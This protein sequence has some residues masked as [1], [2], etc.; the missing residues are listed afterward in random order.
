MTIDVASAWETDDAKPP[1]RARASR[2]RRRTLAFL[3]R[4]R[5]RY[6]FTSIARRIVV[7]NVFGLLVLVAGILYLNQFRAGLIDNRRD[8]LLEHGKIIA[9][10]LADKA[11]AEAGRIAP[12]ADFMLQLP[13][14]SGLDDAINASALSFALDPEIVTPV[15]RQIA[16]LTG[17]RARIY[18]HEGVLLVDSKRLYSSGQVLRFDLPPVVEQEDG[19]LRRFWVWLGK[20]SADK[21]LPVHRDI[22]SANGKAYKEIKVALT[23]EPMNLVS[24]TEKGETIVSVG[25]P[26]QRMRTVMGALLLTSS[27]G[28]IDDIIAKERAAILSMAALV[29]LVTTVLS[30]LLAG[31]IAE[32]MRR[33]AAA[34]ERVPTSMRSPEPIPDFSHRSDEIGHLSR[35]LRNMTS[36]L[37]KRME[38]TECFAADVAHELKNP[39]TSLRSAADTL[40]LA[41]TDDDRAR[42]VGIIQHDVRRLDRLITDISDASRLD[43]ELSR[44]TAEPVDVAALLRAMCGAMNDLHREGAPPIDVRIED[45]GRRGERTAPSFM[46]RGH[47][48][49]LSQVI[50]NIIDNAVSFSPEGGKIYV[51]AR[52]VRRTREIEIAIEDEGPGIAPE[53]LQKVFARFY[54]D[55]PAHEA[56]G[57]NS[58]LG[59]HISQQIVAAHNGRIWAEN[60]INP[61]P[62]R[63]GSSAAEPG[64]IYG[65]RFVI[66]LPVQG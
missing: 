7:L 46:V 63:P 27:E 13:S 34:A 50:A 5:Q 49:R 6:S 43:A 19:L 26:I 29:V 1:K 8:S 60:R 61:A 16:K 23:G 55:R 21:N 36:A 17:M 45:A 58:G 42:L 66:R 40:A 33:L 35:A 47:E 39:L 44:E 31:G 37:F 53:N 12:G 22:G 2:F 41:K 11:N 51:T 30:V 25:V 59:L 54:T 10:T 57:Q 3:R 9:V 14:V 48:S 62:R 20:I 52:P 38:A 18:D 64:R 65:A 32:P 4:M 24:L 28:E 15:I 56:F